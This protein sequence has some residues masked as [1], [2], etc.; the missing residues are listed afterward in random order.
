M[1]I[2]MTEKITTREQGSELQWQIVQ[3]RNREFDNLFFFDVSSTGI[4]CKPSCAAR[5]PKPENTL[6][7]D[8]CAE[9]ENAGFRA[10]L[11]CRPQAE[12][13]RRGS[14]ITGTESDA[15]RIINIQ[16]SYN[17]N[18]CLDLK[19][20]LKGFFKINI[21]CRFYYTSSFLIDK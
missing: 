4:Y 5:R 19:L 2:M 15:D 18:F 17:H 3:N 11:R 21:S 14:G 20:F 12:N 7:F 13:T 1:V 8:T 16:I 10:C 9:V 6:F